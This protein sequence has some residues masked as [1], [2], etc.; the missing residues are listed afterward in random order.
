MFHFD[1]IFGLVLLVDMDLAIAASRRRQRHWWAR[2]PIL[3]IRKSL[4]GSFGDT[5][6][7]LLTAGLCLHDGNGS[8]SQASPSLGV[9]YSQSSTPTDG[10]LLLLRAFEF[11]PNE[12]GLPHPREWRYVQ[13][14]IAPRSF[15]F[16]RVFDSHTAHVCT[17]RR[18][19]LTSVPN[20]KDMLESL[21]SHYSIDFIGTP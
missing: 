13:M 8:I 15:L 19:L 14:S 10:P 18:R 7:R 12:A 9:T 20:S 2:M 5:D 21:T 4:L 1:R 17:N 16:R 3:P 6:I 11:L